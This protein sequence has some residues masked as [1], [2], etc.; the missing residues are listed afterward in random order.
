MYK[1][2][3]FGLIF[4]VPFEIPEFMLTETN[5]HD[6]E[7]AFGK[8][9]PNISSSS[10]FIS[11]SHYKKNDSEILFHV[12]DTADFYI[13]NGNRI[14][15]F[16][17]HSEIPISTIR[18]FLLGTCMGILLQ[19]RGVL[20]LHSSGV[21][22]KHQKYVTLFIGKSGTGKS[23]T[24]SN[25]L[26]NNYLISGDDIQPVIWKHNA[27][28]V[29]PSAPNIKLWEDTLNHYQENNKSS[30]KHEL[31][32]PEINKY[33][34]FIHDQFYNNEVRVKQCI[35]LDWN[36]TNEI[37]CK[38]LTFQEA[39]I[40]YKKNIYRKGF[41][42]LPQEKVRLMAYIHQLAERV[43]LYRLSRNKKKHD[44]KVLH[45]FIVNKFFQD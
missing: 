11:K 2:K 23:T 43:P 29:I 27:P 6:V 28:I 19:Q 26:T 36:D 33:R 3:G 30:V 15:I 35:L 20:S 32:R 4:L 18:I 13:T 42:E 38:Q 1:Y 7:I 9:F 17:N 45:H 24:V 12:K 31:L 34:V 37:I 22:H 40:Y 5:Q 16:P 39:I 10:N 25:F 14:E 21:I 44:S 41:S 8:K